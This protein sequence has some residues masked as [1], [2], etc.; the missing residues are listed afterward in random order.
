LSTAASW[1]SRTTSSFDMYA[2]SLTLMR[3]SVDNI[4]NLVAYYRVA[5]IA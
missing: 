4:R 2:T 5:I 3:N 1:K